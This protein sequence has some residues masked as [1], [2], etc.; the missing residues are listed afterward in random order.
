MAEWVSAPDS[1]TEVGRARPASPTSGPHP[2]H[3]AADLLGTELTDVGS[4]PPHRAIVVARRR[5]GEPGARGRTESAPAPAPPMAMAKTSRSCR[6]WSRPHGRPSVP[7]LSGWS[8]YG[9]GNIR[10]DRGSGIV[11]RC[12]PVRL[13]VMSKSEGGLGTGCP[14]GCSRRP[15]P[16]SGLRPDLQRLAWLE[17]RLDLPASRRTAIT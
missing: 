3:S 17:F 14:G 6:R 12:Y 11:Q 8:P 4:R 9:P 10:V 1:T 2:A 16:L 7:H 15:V 13:D 5:E